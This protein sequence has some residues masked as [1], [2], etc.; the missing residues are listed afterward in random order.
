MIDELHSAHQI[1]GV[2]ALARSYAW[3][4]EIDSDIEA[5]VKGCVVCQQNASAKQIPWP[6]PEHAW[7]H[8]HIDHASPVDGHMLL[9]I[10]SFQLTL[11][12]FSIWHPK[13]PGH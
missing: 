13:K 7:D 3:W 10:A 5:K 11:P 4:P 2:K 6:V 1:S 9:I 12:L 8:I